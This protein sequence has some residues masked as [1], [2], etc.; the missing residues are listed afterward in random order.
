LAIVLL[1]ALHL[2]ACEGSAQENLIALER[3]MMQV[4]S[5][6]ERSAPVIEVQHIL[7]AVKSQRMQDGLSQQAAKALAADLLARIKDDGDFIALMKEH[8]KDPGSKNG[9][10][11]TMHDPKK[12]G[13]APPGAQPRSGM[14]AAFGDVG[15]RL[16][17]GDY[18]VSNYNQTSS[19][20]GYHIIKRVR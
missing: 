19:P 6:T 15:W 18:G 9:G 1:A 20:F 7:V 12:G 11:Y 5:R 16:D 10:S 8:S 4:S 3:S 17:V 14:V 13:E 2:P